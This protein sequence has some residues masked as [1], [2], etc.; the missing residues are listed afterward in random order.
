MSEITKDLI[1]KVPAVTLGFWIIKI[2]CT[3]VGETF[4]DI[5]IRNASGPP[6][7]NGATLRA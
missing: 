7:E 2:L 3:T 5:S 6:A 1:I 4:A